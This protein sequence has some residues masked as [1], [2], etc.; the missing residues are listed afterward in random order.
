ML[1]VDAPF[2]PYSPVEY[3]FKGAPDTS[4]LE[5]LWS[6]WPEAVSPDGHKAELVQ[7]LGVNHATWGVDGFESRGDGKASYI[8]WSLLSPAERKV[9]H[10]RWMKMG[11]EHRDGDL[12]A[13]I[14]L[15]NKDNGVDFT[16][17]KLGLVHRI[18][19]AATLSMGDK[20][21]NMKAFYLYNEA[22]SETSFL[23]VHSVAI[24][25]NIPLWLAFAAH[26]FEI[27]LGPVQVFHK[28][29]ADLADF[30]SEW[31]AKVFGMQFDGKGS[32]ITNKVEGKTYEPIYY[33]LPLIQYEKDYAGA[34]TGSL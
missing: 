14:W 32:L 34:E 8:Q 21:G 18:S 3:V 12:P 22:L 5:D 26:M 30:P 17:Y 2:P 23:K 4:N 11:K 29:Y 20:H 28:K 27:D 25:Y 1:I 6:D 7:Q 9:E 10:L 24:Q 15:Y 13:E 19:C 31:I 33:V 16:F